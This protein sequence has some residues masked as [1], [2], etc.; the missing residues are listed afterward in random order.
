MT[1]SAG[2][3]EDDFQGFVWTLVEA[4][5]L[6]SMLKKKKEG[7][8]VAL[9]I[10]ILAVAL[11]SAELGMA[12]EEFLQLA[13]AARNLPDDAMEALRRY[14]EKLQHPDEGTAVGD[15]GSGT[16]KSFFTPRYPLTRRIRFYPE[17]NDGKSL[18]CKA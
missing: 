9:L 4:S 7:A 18:I 14:Q 12:E 13:R 3:P 6:V 8:E 17:G 2:M 1:E 15:G 16:K 10:G 5:W 11:L